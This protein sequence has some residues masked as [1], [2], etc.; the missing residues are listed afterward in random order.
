MGTNGSTSTWAAHLTDAWSIGQNPN[1]GYVLAAAVRAMSEALP[2]HPD[3][4]T[5]TSHY[6]RPAQ[7][8]PA[9]ISVEIIR[10]GRKHATVMAALVQ[11]DKERIR[12]LGTFG[13]LAEPSGPNRMEATPPHLPPP[14]QCVRREEGHV[15]GSTIGSRVDILLHPE[16]GWI[17]G[18]P[19]GTA[20]LSGWA[21]FKDGRPADPLALVFFAD[22]FP[23]ALFDS[24]EEK[25]WLPT[26]ELTVHV[27]A[28]PAPGPL[29]GRTRT[30]FLLNGYLEEDGELWDSADRLV[31]QSRQLG[32]L[33]RP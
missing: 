7:P 10:L 2:R 31:A 4:F 24:L 28:K 19:A 29:R 14:G 9:T 16:T 22:G 20:S 3:P 26:I 1:G 21:S 5:V 12:V 15:D 17:R 30:R 27:R 11:D 32:M 33:F 8:G 18:T 23:P 25:V 13:D 6:L